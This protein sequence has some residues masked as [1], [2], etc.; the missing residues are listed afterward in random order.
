MIDRELRCLRR[1]LGFH[2]VWKNDVKQS[3]KVM[4]IW[5]VRDT[6]GKIK[7]HLLPLP[8]HIFTINQSTKREFKANLKLCFTND[9][10]PLNDEHIKYF[11][12]DA[13]YKSP[14]LYCNVSHEYPPEH[15]FTS[16]ECIAIEIHEKKYDDD[17]E[18]NPRTVDWKECRPMLFDFNEK[19]VV[20]ITIKDG[21]FEFKVR[22]PLR[23]DL[24]RFF[25]FKFNLDEETTMERAKSLYEYH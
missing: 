11:Y 8:R 16:K 5:I 24:W 17:P 3:S 22:V 18:I 4:T 6:Y 10:F 21:Y 23:G 7:E 13:G 2:W 1:E 19:K 14:L 12:I 25:Q 9:P 20:S 15:V